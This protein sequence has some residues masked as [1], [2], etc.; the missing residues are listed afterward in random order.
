MKSNSEISPKYV[1][2]MFFGVFALSVIY[3]FIGA[4]FMNSALTFYEYLVFTSLLTVVVLGV[5]QVFFWVQR[6]NYFFETKC[7]KIKLDDYIPFW[8][9]WI[10]IYSFLYYVLI[11]Y[12]LISIKSIEE[13]YL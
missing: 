2:L 6:N 11:G 8:P 13:N 1:L 4:R 5:Y 12:V 3:Y 10:W 9:G 7:L